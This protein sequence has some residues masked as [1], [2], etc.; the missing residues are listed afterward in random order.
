MGS[1]AL[2]SNLGVLALIAAAELSRF[3]VVKNVSGVATLIDSAADVPMGVT[4]DGADAAGDITSLEV[5][6]LGET[7]IGKCSGAISLNDWI[8]PA[9]DGSGDIKKLPTAPGSYW[10]IGQANIE[11]GADD[12]EIVYTD[13]VPRLVVV[14]AH[15]ADASVGHA[16]NATFSDTEVEGAL[17]ALGG[18]VNA[19][20]AALEAASILKSS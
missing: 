11:A 16:L 12:Q 10:V 17:D 9:V 20:L 3:K 5:L 18:K 15:I 8:V 7:K 19:I 1:R 6:G 14:Q 13:C 2:K 4:R